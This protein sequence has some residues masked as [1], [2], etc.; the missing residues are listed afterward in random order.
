MAQRNSTSRERKAI[1]RRLT[2][3][4]DAAIPGAAGNKQQSP[5]RKRGGTRTPAR[6]RARG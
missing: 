4:K 5:G 6:Q 1:A 2:P 3:G